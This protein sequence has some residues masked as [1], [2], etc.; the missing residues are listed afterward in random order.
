[1]RGR[2][3]VVGEIEAKSGCDW[4]NLLGVQGGCSILGLPYPSRSALS[5]ATKPR[6]DKLE[7][8]F[9]TKSGLVAGRRVSFND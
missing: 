9:Q 3:L 1:M 2:P 6:P 4:V 8:P 5:F 7:A